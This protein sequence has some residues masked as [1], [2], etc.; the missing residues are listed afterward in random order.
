MLGSAM[1]R[2]AVKYSASSHETTATPAPPRPT[3][4]RAPSC[5]SATSSSTTA[6]VTKMSLNP[7]TSRKCSSSTIGAAWRSATERRSAVAAAWLSAPEA[8]AASMS[9]SLYMPALPVAGGN[10]AGVCW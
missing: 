10:V 8:T 2:R 6:M 1:R 7:V 9:P 3:A 4:T 5:A